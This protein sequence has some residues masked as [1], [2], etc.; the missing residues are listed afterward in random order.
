MCVCGSVYVRVSCKCVKLVYVWAL[1][2][3]LIRQ[4]GIS[5]LSSRLRPRTG[6][7]EDEFES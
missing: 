4:G 6:E 1:V 2:E 7:I 5:Q 3:H